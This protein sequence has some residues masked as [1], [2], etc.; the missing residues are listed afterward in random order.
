MFTLYSTTLMPSSTGTT[1]SINGDRARRAPVQ[2]R[3]RERVEE[4]LRAAERLV[5][6]GGVDAL[7]TRAVATTAHVPVASVYQYFADRDAIMAAL[8]ERHVLAMDEQLAVEVTALETFSVRTLLQ[9][10]VAA[11]VAGYR[12]RPSYVILWFQGR[13]SPEI[14]TFVRNRSEDLATRFHT[15]S[16]AAGL[17]RPET[18]VLV[19]ELA[20]EMIDAFLAV[21]YRDDI[22]GDERVVAQGI[23]MITT[24][25]ERHATP[26]GINGVPAAEIAGRLEIGT[27]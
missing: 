17:V 26:A 2:H 27:T 18:D 8:I 7:T 6:R 20:A 16:V 1:G 12:Q 3:S 15:F 13:V 10:T 19:F 23:E 21:A 24:Y 25:I 11:Y 14:A 9:A 4:I 5:V 22:G